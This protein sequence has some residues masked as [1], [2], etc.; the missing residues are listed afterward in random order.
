MNRC[1]VAIDMVKDYLG[2]MS[3][4]ERCHIVE[5]INELVET[6]RAAGKVAVL[7]VDETRQTR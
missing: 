3:E 2:R 4:T 1:L 7:A 6:F 5:A